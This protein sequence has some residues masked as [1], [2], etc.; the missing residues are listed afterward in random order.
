MFRA[1]FSFLSLAIA[2]AGWVA[3]VPGPVVAAFAPTGLYSGHWGVDLGAP[4]GTV[5]TAPVS[6]VVTF[7][8]PVASI[9]AVTI[10]TESG[11][12]VSV[13]YLAAVSVTAGEVVASGDPIGYS[14][15]AHGSPGVHLSLRVDGR[16]V[17]PL[18]HCGG[19]VGRGRLRLLPPL[20]SVLG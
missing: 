13:S 3:P 11:W 14:G 1:A 19:L 16:Y 2:C 6:G 5:V 9:E 20:S 15:L 7:A 10:T 17:D 18:Q 8:G 4:V 12:R